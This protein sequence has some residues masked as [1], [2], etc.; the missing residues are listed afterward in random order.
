MRVINNSTRVAH[1]PTVVAHHCARVT[2]NSLLV[3]PNLSSVARNRGPVTANFARVRKYLTCVPR[4]LMAE[5][6]AFR[7]GKH[8]PYAL[9]AF[10]LS[11]LTFPG[12]AVT[13]R[14]TRRSSTLAKFLLVTNSRCA[15]PAYHTF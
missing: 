14:V 5:C 6:R 4:Y 3:V 13:K 2:P 1:N 8:V 15:S 11:N 9:F 7:C 12:Q 10:F